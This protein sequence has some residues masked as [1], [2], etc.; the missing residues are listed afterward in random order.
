[1][2]LEL[3]NQVLIEPPRNGRADSLFIVAGYASPGYAKD[4]L[5]ALLDQ[6]PHEIR[7][8]LLIGMRSDL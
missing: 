1:M 2:A 6:H 3:R 7:V 4:H 5:D 8:T